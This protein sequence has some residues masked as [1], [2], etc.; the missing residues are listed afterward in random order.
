MKNV[1]LVLKIY[2]AISLKSTIYLNNVKK[3]IRSCVTGS[4]LSLRCINKPI[5]AVWGISPSFLSG[6]FKKHGKTLC[7]RNG[8]ILLAKTLVIPIANT[9]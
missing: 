6:K 3:K 2:N 4:T 5:M 8:E 9:V 7:G 1:N